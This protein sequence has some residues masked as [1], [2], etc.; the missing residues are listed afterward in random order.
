MRYAFGRIFAKYPGIR[1]ENTFGVRI[2]TKALMGRGYVTEHCSRLSS[3]LLVITECV[4]STSPP[5][6][7]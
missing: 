6:D 3:F 5:F 4:R 2:T 1:D 7:G